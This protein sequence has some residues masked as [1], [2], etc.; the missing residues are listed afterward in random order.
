MTTHLTAV[1]NFQNCYLNCNLH[2]APKKIPRTGFH[3]SQTGQKL[4]KKI[5]PSA[6][7][8]QKQHVQNSS[9]MHHN[10]NYS[11]Q[12]E[13]RHNITNIIYTQKQCTAAQENGPTLE[14]EP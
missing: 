13:R 8:N 6:S 12:T 7:L 11:K 2:F 1:T 10:L 3:V 5:F 14:T 4:C 9:P